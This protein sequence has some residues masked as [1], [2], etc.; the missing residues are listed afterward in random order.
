MAIDGAF[1]KV[2]SIIAG[3][4]LVRGRVVTLLPGLSTDLCWGIAYRLTEKEAPQILATLD[5]RE[6]GG[7]VQRFETLTDATGEHFSALI[8]MATAQ[9]P[10]YLGPASLEY[11]ARQIAS[12]VGPSGTNIDYLFN[13]AQAL[14]EWGVEDEHVMDLERR[15][16]ALFPPED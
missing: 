3:S 5:Y 2:Q 1:G 10:Y 15:V 4:P 16:I 11:M 8:Y 14:C 9:N 6:R 13:L 7:Y 12:A